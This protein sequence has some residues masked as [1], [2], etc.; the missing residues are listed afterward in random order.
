M[1]E[2]IRGFF[3]NI[4]GLFHNHSL[5][6]ITGIDTNLSSGMYNAIELWSF[7]IVVTCLY[8]LCKY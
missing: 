8:W 5:K 3:M 7:Y 2:K 4:L 6:E 1:F